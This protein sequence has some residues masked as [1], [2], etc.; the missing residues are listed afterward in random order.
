M[1]YA[2]KKHYALCIMNY[3]LNK[4]YALCIMN[5]ALIVLALQG[6][7]KMEIDTAQW[8]EIV[9]SNYL[10]DTVDIYHEWDLLQ[11]RALTIK[12]DLDD[13]DLERV[14]ILNGNPYETEGV[15]ILTER[16]VKY[17]QTVNP[18]FHV[19]FVE[20]DYYA[21]AVTAQGQYTVVPFNS[22]NVA[23]FANNSKAVA[24]GVLNRPIYQTYTYLFEEDF[25]LPGDFDFNDVVLRIS[26]QAV[27]DSTLKLKVTLS[28]VG[29]AKQVGGA[30]RMPNIPYD[31]VKRVAIEEGIRF[32]ETLTTNRYY[33][34]ND[35]VYVSGRDGSTVI[36][37]FD[38]AHWS[39]LPKEEYGQVVRMFYNTRKFEVKNEST[40]VPEQSRT[41]IIYLK[42]G[43]AASYLELPDIDPFIIVN[44]N[45]LCT[46]VHTYKYKYDEAIW[47][48]TN[49]PSAEDDHVPWAL[50]IPDG[51]F[52]YPVEAMFIGRYRNGESTGAYSRSNHSFGEWGRD[53]DKARDWWLYDYASKAQVY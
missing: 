36:N 38:D 51:Q 48:Y 23:S 32:D 15:E 10:V 46:E 4:H 47:H 13:P 19:P 52:H 17:G 6:C 43:L 20:R 11:T 27:N 45:G 22:S 16:F 1:N 8:K 49:G 50:L 28:A 5:Y 42:S 34:D 39:L 31:M 21:A 18:I 40:K 7:R 29:A 2:L 44:N 14:Q 25:P 26:Q 53:H 24:T 12:A 3:A 37:L 35:K 41:Y 30:I 33:I 9:Q